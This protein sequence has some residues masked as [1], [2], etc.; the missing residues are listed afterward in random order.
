LLGLKTQAYTA[1]A[2][3]VQSWK[4]CHRPD[5]GG[6]QD[7]IYGAL[8]YAAIM[9]LFTLLLLAWPA[10]VTWLPAHM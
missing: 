3:T 5:K 8:P 4:C 1:G 2:T 9:I 6:I 10:L 7:A